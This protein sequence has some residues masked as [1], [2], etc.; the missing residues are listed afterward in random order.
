MWMMNQGNHSNALYLS[1]GGGFIRNDPLNYTIFWQ[2]PE[3]LCLEIIN[4]RYSRFSAAHREGTCVNCRRFAPN[5]CCSCNRYHCIWQWRWV[6][7]RPCPEEQQPNNDFCGFCDGIFCE[8]CYNERVLECESGWCDST[9]CSYCQF[10]RGLH[11]FIIQ[12]HHCN[13]WQCEDEF[14]DP[15]ATVCR[16]CS[17]LLRVL[18]NRNPVY[19]RQSM[20]YARAQYSARNYQENDSD[21]GLFSDSSGGE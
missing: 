18:E 5:L 3:D 9:I 15:G 13:I 21:D 14:E 10:R 6:R 17:I 12:C 1:P 4:S 2:L 8:E 19:A 20:D 11:Q 7:H 16:P